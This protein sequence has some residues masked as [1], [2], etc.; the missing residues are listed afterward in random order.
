MNQKE[1][2]SFFQRLLNWL[3][4]LFFKKELEL[5]ILGIQNAGKTTLVEYLA[6]EKFKEDQ[7]PTIGFNYKEMTKGKVHFKCWD[8]G[9][10]YLI[11]GDNLDSGILGRS[12]VEQQMLLYM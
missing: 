10:H 4:S 12:I 2:P 8:M 9:I 1:E 7:I 3:K 11:K 5:A 6:T